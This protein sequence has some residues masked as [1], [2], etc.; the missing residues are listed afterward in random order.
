[1]ESAANSTVISTNLG[2]ATYANMPLNLWV[3]AGT[4]V[5][6][7][8]QANITTTVPGAFYM[9]SAAPSTTSLTTN[10]PAT[11]NATYG[12]AVIDY[13]GNLIHIPAAS[14]INRIADSWPAHNTIVVMVG[15]KNKLV[16]TSP[17]DKVILMFQKILPAIKDMDAPFDSAGTP[18]V[19]QLLAI[20]PDIV[21][22]SSTSEAPA[23]TMENAGLLVVRLNF[24][25]FPDMTKCVQLTGWILGED[26]LAKANA[27]I[28]YFNQVYNNITSVTSQIP[29]SQKPSIYHISGNSPLYC[30]GNGTL[31]DSWITACGGTNAAALISGNGKQVTFEQVLSWNPDV[32]LIGSAQANQF[33]TQILGD[34]Q[35]SQIK[36]VQNGKVI[37]NPMGVF[38]WSRYS[39]EEALNLQW[40]AKTLY[41]DKFANID[42]RA[43]TKF[44]YQTFYGYNLSE[45]EVDA[46]IN[47]L[48]PPM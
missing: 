37:V 1:L 31:G 14:K 36:A 8:Y 9:I 38:D 18:S 28:T 27:Y 41:P 24:L 47:N 6:Y 42:I 33:K 13:N 23:K 22:V 25:N 11:I 2:T 35:W 3:D 19:E 21:F 46:I 43:Q 29:A 12:R 15:A 5:T 48:P 40:V 26:A 17:T 34:A 44:F 16:A 7:N 45:A 39:V 20:N 10:A 32:I 30:D 4:Q